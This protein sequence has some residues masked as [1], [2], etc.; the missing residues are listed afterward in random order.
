MPGGPRPEPGVFTP[1]GHSANSQPGDLFSFIYDRLAVHFND[2][3]AAQVK[4]E[5]IDILAG[6]IGVSTVL[7]L[8]PFESNFG[9]F[10][11]GGIIR[12]AM[13]PFVR[14]LIT[15]PADEWLNRAF[16]F[17]PIPERTA[18]TMMSD[19]LITPQDVTSIAI[20]NGI[21]DEYLPLL[22]KYGQ[23]KRAQLLQGFANQQGSEADASVV[24]P[25]ER[26]LT[27][28]EPLLNQLETEIERAETDLMTASLEAQVSLLSRTATALEN[29]ANKADA[30]T[31]DKKAKALGAVVGQMV[32]TAEY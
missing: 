8:I 9:A 13:Q 5:A 4:S 17:G 10:A 7:S 1:P 25:Y 28:I 15:D 14:R 2:M 19:G 12:D 6:V 22:I 11:A 3:D 18:L 30:A 32:V 23:V 31:E 24:Y 21:R 20:R 26:T 16:R 27:R 29:A